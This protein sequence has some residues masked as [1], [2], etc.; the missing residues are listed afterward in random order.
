MFSSGVIRCP[1]DGQPERGV[2]RL[3]RGATGGV[4]P[5]SSAH[6]ACHSRSIIFGRRWITT[7][8]NEPIASPNTAAR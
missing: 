1:Q 4:S 3:N 7:F 5:R 8:R 2:T 6:C